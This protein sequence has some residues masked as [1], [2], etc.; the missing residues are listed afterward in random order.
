MPNPCLQIWARTTQKH[1]GRGL[2]RIVQQ[3]ISQRNVHLCT[4][5]V[6]LIS[7]IVLLFSPDSPH[8]GPSVHQSVRRQFH[9]CFVPAN[10]HLDAMSLLPSRRRSVGDFR[11]F[12]ARTPA[13]S[14]EAMAFSS[15]NMHQS[16]CSLQRHRH[17]E[18][19]HRSYPR[20]SPRIHDVESPNSGENKMPDRRALRHQNH[21]SP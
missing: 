10:V 2:I 16:A 1:S 6:Y 20:H 13:P 9:Y 15:R 8:S 17:H 3:G 11:N 12:C 19:H 14:A 18:R 7:C 5:P 21:V 4:S